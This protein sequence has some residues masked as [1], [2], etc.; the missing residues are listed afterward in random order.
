MVANFSNEICKILTGA[1]LGTC[2]EVEHQ[3]E[4]WGGEESAAMVLLPRHLQDLVQRSTTTL[5][6][7]LVKRMQHTPAKDADNL[8]RHPC[9]PM[10]THC[11]RKEPDPV[12]HWLQEMSDV[13]WSKMRSAWTHRQKKRPWWVE[14]YCELQIIS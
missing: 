7:E 3:A 13:S 6:E 12:C 8:S 9:E 4:Q 2:E 14:D 5:M 10:C 1:K 11:T